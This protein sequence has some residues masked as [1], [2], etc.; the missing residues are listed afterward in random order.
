VQAILPHEIQRVA[1][2]NDHRGNEGKPHESEVPEDAQDATHTISRMQHCARG[3]W[4]TFAVQI[5]INIIMT[6]VRNMS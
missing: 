2:I 1:Y 4:A 3:A 5:H 6:M